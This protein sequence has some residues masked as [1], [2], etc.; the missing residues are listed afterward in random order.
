MV[1]LPIEAILQIA[2]VEVIVASVENQLQ[3]EVMYGI[4]I[5]A[6]ALIS[7]SVDT[8]FDLISL[9]AQL[10]TILE[11]CRVFDKIFKE[12]DRGLT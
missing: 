4:K 3:I 12:L 1:Q 7:D 10:Y 2:G 6:D 5:V 8:E 9:P 11:L